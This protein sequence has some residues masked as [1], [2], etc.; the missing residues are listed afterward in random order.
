[1]PDEPKTIWLVRDAY[2]VWISH[3][4]ETLKETKDWHK[5]CDKCHARYGP[6]HKV[7][8]FRE[9]IETDE[10]KREPRE[11]WLVEEGGSCGRGCVGEPWRT[12]H[13]AQQAAT[14]RDSQ[15]SYN[16]PH[17][18]VR[19]REVVPMENECPKSDVGA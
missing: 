13:T 12:E 18:V 3:W 6:P 4:F 15:Y 2:G 17:R 11:W 5:Y 7:C 10:P 1:M 9:V 8:C 16:A 14:L 19:V